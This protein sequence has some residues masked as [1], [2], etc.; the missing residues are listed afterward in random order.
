MN[1]LDDHE[2]LLWA[3]RAGLNSNEVRQGLDSGRT[4]PGKRPRNSPAATGA[5][6]DHP[7]LLPGTVP[8]RLPGVPGQAGSRREA[9]A[10]WQWRQTC[11][12]SN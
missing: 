3:M 2:L 8:G 10:E 6:T 7:G 1:P 11:V 4:P 9:I 12:I 5:L